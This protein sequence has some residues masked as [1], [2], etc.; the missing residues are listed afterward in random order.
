MSSKD[1]FL[2]LPLPLLRLLANDIL[3]A[4]ALGSDFARQDQERPGV[5][6]PLSNR[7]I[8]SLSCFAKAE[9]LLLLSP[10]RVGSPHSKLSDVQLDLIVPVESVQWVGH[11]EKFTL[12]LNPPLG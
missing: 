7:P 8:T 12:G 11:S 2:R 1:D 6:R 9:F 3:G 5:C 4:D 10:L